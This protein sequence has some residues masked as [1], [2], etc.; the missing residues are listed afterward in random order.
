MRL[1][2]ELLEDRRLLSISLNG[3]PQWH[4]EGPGPIV[5]SSLVAGI[6]DPVNPSV[7]AI[8]SLAVDPDNADV[9]YIGSVTGG[10]W[11]TTNATDA[12]PRWTPLT[13][14]LPSLSI[15]A[16]A[17][18]PL[19][20]IVVYAGL[21]RF[22]RVRS[23]ESNAPGMG[24]RA[25][26][27][28]ILRS[29]D[30]GATWSQHGQVEFADQSVRSIVPGALLP[31][32]QVV[33]AGTVVG[34]SGDTF[35]TAMA[36]GLYR[37]VDFGQTWTRVSGS[38]GLPLGDVSDV[39][40]DPTNPHRYF[41]AIAGDFD[42]NDDGVDN[43]AIAWNNKG[44]Y[45]SN[46][47]GVTWVRITSGMQLGIRQSATR[48]ELSAQGYPALNAQVMYAAIVGADGLSTIYRSTDRGSSWAGWLY[49]LSDS[50]REGSGLHFLSLLAD[51]DDPRAVWISGNNT[52]PP[53]GGSVGV[54]LRGA[55]GPGGYSFQR[56]ILNSANGSAPHEDSR[57]MV[58]DADGHLLE[59]DDGGIYRLRNP[60]QTSRRWESAN[61]DL[62]ISELYSI[63][64]DSIADT[65]IGGTQDNG[66]AERR[67]PDDLVWDAIHGGDG[68]YTAVDLRNP[69]ARLHYSSSQNLGGFE[70]QVYDA[71][72]QR[73]ATVDI[74]LSV[75]QTAPGLRLG[76][77]DPA[78]RYRFV[79]DP[80]I[81]QV[82]PYVLNVVN[83]DRMLIGTKFLYESLNR[84][85]S[86]TSLGGVAN[87]NNDGLDNDN[88]GSA[89]AADPEQDEFI[90]VDWGTDGLDNDGDG[91]ADSQDIDGDGT[92]D[93]LD[94]DEPSLGR[95]TS[96]IY[97]GF[98][99]ANPLEFM[100]IIGTTS[101]LWMA[102]GQNDQG[103][104]PYPTKVATYLGEAYGPLS[105]TRRTRT[106]STSPTQRARSGTAGISAAIGS[107]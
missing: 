55:D 67:D 36:G 7:G 92:L 57:D 89:D 69:D 68:N 72:N 76:K 91:V 30:A 60:S 66:T 81:H 78:D 87:L 84:G 33:L 3:F 29:T 79:F 64:Y 98:I 4:E 85:Q 63:A 32:G 73:T 23:P 10:V 20:D 26:L 38:G 100:A 90:V 1:H 70:Y 62:R 106:I 80:S 86:V 42:S 43:D 88:D 13:D 95:V 12:A 40:I 51:R 61:G 107:I 74:A 104:L 31:T 65:L 93:V 19:D 97:G 24:D 22:S 58:Y 45:L 83:P 25:P 35:G 47:D 15:G 71:L 44:V 34:G 75:N 56:M 50:D 105:R 2:G 49:D 82:A 41:A 18:S 103:V 14:Q 96:M 46:D 99:G 94:V 54:I 48:I 27:T 37:S 39:I 101:G 77:Q 28:G 16:V 5:G 11:K 6:S 9:I 17:L 53:G 102:T 21:G 52:R 59:V 8:E